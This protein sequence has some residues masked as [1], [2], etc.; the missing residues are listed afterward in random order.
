MLDRTVPSSRGP[1]AHFAAALVAAAAVVLLPLGWP[2]GA[3][4]PGLE[5]WWPATLA[6]MAAAL[7]YAMITAMLHGRLFRHRDYRASAVEPWIDALLAL[8]CAALLWRG[9]DSRLLLAGLAL[10]PPVLAATSVVSLAV[11]I[12]D[13]RRRSLEGVPT[14]M[15]F[16]WRLLAAI[17]LIGA[18][19]WLE[20]HA[21]P[22]AA[23]WVFPLAD[24]SG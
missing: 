4:E 12:F 3:A 20:S 14:T 23:A 24:A 19:A 10:A 15:A 1:A 17:A 9:A 18:I 8:E 22:S 2:W 16:S 6:A 5:S 13:L 11:L 7:A 21:L